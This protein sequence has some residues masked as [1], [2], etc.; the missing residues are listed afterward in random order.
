MTMGPSLEALP[1]KRL[2]RYQ[3]RLR[4]FLCLPFAMAFVWWL[5]GVVVD[6]KA[7]LIETRQR[8]RDI[9]A[10]IALHERKAIEYQASAEAEIPDQ[11]TELQLGPDRISRRVTRP[12]S[13]FEIEERKILRQN[14]ALR[15]VY[16]LD[17]KKKYESASWAPWRLV[18]RDPPPPSIPWRHH[19][20]IL[21][22]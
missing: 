15:A 6:F 12:F 9:R 8:W 7:S 16:H 10:A 17:M 13:E 22:H 19:S 1:V 4:T 5:S 3:L 11:V 20:P 2:G 18:Q 21:H 14:A